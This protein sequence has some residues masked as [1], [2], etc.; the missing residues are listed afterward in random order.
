MEVIYLKVIVALDDNLGMMFNHRRQSRDRIL[1]SDIAEMVEGK[2]IYIDK[3]SEILFSNVPCQYIIS[4]NPLEE[5]GT[6]DY[7]FIEQYQLSN[8]IDKINELIIYRWNRTYPHDFDFDIDLENSNFKITSTT[9]F[10]GSS[11]DK[12]T[13]EVYIK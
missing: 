7:C 6:D 2:K 12:I 1:I 13:R 3:Y 5:T 8:Y 10:K 9:E 11:H 4:S